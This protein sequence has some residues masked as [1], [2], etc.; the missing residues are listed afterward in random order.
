MTTYLCAPLIT[1]CGT[2][3]QNF[4][5]MW[6]VKINQNARKCPLSIPATPPR[7]IAA[8]PG[9]N[10]NGKIWNLETPIGSTGI[11]TWIPQGQATSSVQDASAARATNVLFAQILR[12]IIMGL[13]AAVEK[14][15]C[16]ERIPVMDGRRFVFG[17]SNIDDLH[18][19]EVSY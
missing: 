12:L 3:L 1:S 17:T 18:Y 4:D 10:L 14:L 11:Y 16:F 8:P 7:G 2:T 9:L 15:S 13:Q 5:L 6:V 19:N